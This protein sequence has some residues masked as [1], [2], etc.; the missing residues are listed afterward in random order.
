MSQLVGQS[1]PVAPWTTLVDELI[2][3][4][5]FQVTGDKPVHL[6]RFAESWDGND[7]DLVTEFDD[8]L[9]GD[10]NNPGWMMTLQKGISSA[11]QVLIREDRRT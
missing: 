8:L 4:D 6:K 5:S 9:N 7:V 3:R 11:G 1:E 10:R 2:Y